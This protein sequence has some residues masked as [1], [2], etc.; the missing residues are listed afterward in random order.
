MMKKLHAMSI[1]EKNIG[2]AVTLIRLSF[3]Y[4]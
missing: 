2:N 4:Q 1:G 3:H